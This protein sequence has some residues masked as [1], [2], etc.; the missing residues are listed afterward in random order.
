MPSSCHNL[1]IAGYNLYAEDYTH[2]STSALI[3]HR[4]SGWQI[5]V[6]TAISSRRGGLSKDI[7]KSHMKN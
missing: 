2:V 7:I 3:D 5:G 4:V 6:H 1:A